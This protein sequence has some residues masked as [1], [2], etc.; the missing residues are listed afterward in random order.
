[1]WS[2]RGRGFPNDIAVVRFSNPFPV[3]GVR[4][5]PVAMP[6]SHPADFTSSE[7]W[8]SGWGRMSGGKDIAIVHSL[9]LMLLLAN[10]TNT[11]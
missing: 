2:P 4:I 11:K 9:T 7:C 3:D 1:M 8:I 6:S 5:N 10:L